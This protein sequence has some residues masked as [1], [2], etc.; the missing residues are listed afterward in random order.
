MSRQPETIIDEADIRDKD[1]LLEMNH[2]LMEDERYDRPPTQDALQR[3][4]NEFLYL[5][6]YGVY[7]F[8]AADRRVVGYAVVH[9]D[10]QPRYLRHF[11]IRREERRRGF[12]T[13]AFHALLR[14]LDVH[15]IDLDVMTW[16]ERG[17]GFWRSLGFRER[18]RAM[19]YD[20]EIYG[21]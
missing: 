4:W 17:F 8:R 13:S 9:L 12:G 21:G 6:R 20:P 19:A 18:C 3:R 16:N 11:Y 14:A 5:D 10:D 1:L 15:R 7:L 2:R